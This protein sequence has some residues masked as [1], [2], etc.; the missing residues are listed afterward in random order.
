MVTVRFHKSRFPENFGRNYHN[1]GQD[2]RENV[3]LVIVFREL[4]DKDYII[5]I[6]PRISI[7]KNNPD[8]PM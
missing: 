7:R 1:A 8:N 6:K 2:F 5:Y 4:S 3:H